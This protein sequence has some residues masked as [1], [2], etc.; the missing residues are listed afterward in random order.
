V[1][2]LLS[3]E[4]LD[5]RRA[6]AAGALA[7]LVASLRAELD[8]LRG[9]GA[10][11]PD[12]KALL[13]RDG[14]R[15]PREGAALAFDP[16]EPDRHRCLTCGDE[17]GGDRHRRWWVMSRH[18]WLAERALH[19]AVLWAVTGDP[20]LARLSAGI[21]ERYADRYLAYPNRDNVLG[22]SRPFFST[23]LESIWLLQLALALDMLEMSG[24]ADV[25]SQAVRSRLLEPSLE[26]I[27]GFDEGE[28]NRQ[29]WHNAALVAAGQLVD[30]SGLVRR[31]VN[32]PSGLHAHLEGALLADGTWYEGENYHLFAHRGLW[33]GVALAEQAGITIPVELAHRF[34]EGFAAP[35]FT[36]LPDFTFPAR[37]DSKYGVSLRNWRFA[38]SCELGLARRD[39]PRLTTALGRLYG[40]EAERRG[41][42]RWCSA[43]EAEQPEPPSDLSRA[44]L[45][46]KSLL[47]AR[48]LIP[49]LPD[50]VPRTV[51]LDGQGIAVFRRGGGRTFVAV[52][53]GQS[54]GGHGHPDRLNL[55][56]VDGEARWLDDMGT[57]SYVDPSLHWY[58]SSLAHNAP[59]ADGRSQRPG[60]GRLLAFEE[61]G[62]AG[63]AHVEVPSGVLAGDVHAARTLVV[64]PDYAVDQVVWQ[65][66]RP[67]ALDLPMH[68]D[69]HVDGIGPWAERS[70]AASDAP[71]DGFASVHDIEAA[72]VRAGDVVRLRADDGTRTLD[73]WLMPSAAAELWRG[74]APG[75]P[76]KGDRR[77]L[78]IRLHER[79]GGITTV[80]SWD[81]AVRAAA[82]RDGVLTLDLA[83][84]ER[85]E[86]SRVDREWHVELLAGEAR[87]SIDLGGTRLPPRRETP[88]P[89]LRAMVPSTVPRVV[90]GRVRPAP[91]CVQLGEREYRRS[92]ESWEQ[93]GMP[94]ATVTLL[95]SEREL[96]CGV[97]VS[98][99]PVYF[100]PPDA[101]DPGLDNEPPDI[102]S[103]GV[104][105]YLG[106]PSWDT[107]AGWLLVPE[108]GGGVRINHVAGTKR[109]APLRTTWRLTESGYE[110]HIRIPLSALGRGPDYP[111][112]ASVIVNEMVPGRERRRGQLVIGGGAGEFVYLRG[113]RELPSRFL[114]FVVPR[115]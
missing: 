31:A 11:V 97:F 6:V 90:P 79:T 22:P 109:D 76:G 72:P 1:T 95:A 112:S 107:E 29:V 9:S 50:E 92:E 24:A 34:A 47:F 78:W 3:R 114:H 39:D 71:H 23:Y 86:H 94:T 40:G 113:D 108:P 111:F 33:Y 106:S 110:M 58:R 93:A 10:E 7:P 18:L 56:L 68:L 73:G 49:D 115:G 46:W 15:C 60:E 74:T 77:F 13:S 12:E 36:V 80:W 28:S 51:L 20:V 16:S 17:V 66:G 89:L 41:T 52:D 26:L 70:P 43:A 67:V 53:Y 61:R 45:S 35:L 44:D 42:L 19:G 81:G 37:R 64:M 30:Q 98:K 21:L 57:G 96:E 105:I 14:G 102:H 63:W 100:R 25:P 85:H 32:G 48:P 88:P 5:E 2:L 65:S 83:T 75:A 87:S 27:A 8:P 101:A 38:E 82:A 103:D 104:Q 55:L 59:L 4:A 84:G 99:Q 54:G 91:L 62:A 69:A